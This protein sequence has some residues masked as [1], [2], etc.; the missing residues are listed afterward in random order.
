MQQDALSVAMVIPTYK[1]VLDL[2]RCLESIEQQY[3]R[4]DSVIVGTHSWD[5]ESHAFLESYRSTLDFRQTRADQKGFLANMQAALDT[6]SEDIVCFLD[7]DVAL[8]PD[9]LQRVLAHFDADPRVGGVGG[10]DLLQ[11]EPEKRGAE[12]TTERVG[13][14]T[15]YGRYHGNHHRG[16]GG[17]REVNCLKGCN[18]AYR[19]ELIR[20]FGFDHR[21]RGRG[22][23]VGSELSLAFDIRKADFKLVYDSEIQVDHFVAVRHDND[24]LHRGGFDAEATRDL[25]FNYMLIMRTKAPGI[26]FVMYVLWSLVWGSPK[27][28]GVFRN[29]TLA[30]SDEHQWSRSRAFIGGAI[31]AIS[32]R[33]TS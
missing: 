15:W 24:Q 4:P 23:Q 10:R 26:L 1:R 30:R 25:A 29:L 9:W 11:D 5:E 6:T 14:F 17:A 7:D 27:T 8:H 13:I 22:A 2:K 12:A 33:R 32:I 16:R 20:R 31:S 28:P 18:C 21:L 19:G 3:L